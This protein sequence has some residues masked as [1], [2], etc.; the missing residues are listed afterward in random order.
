MRTIR[1]LEEAREIS[2]IRLTRQRRFGQVGD[3]FR[4]SPQTGIFLWGR[5]V[6]KARFFGHDFE[7][8][9]VYIYDAIGSERPG[10]ELL[11]PSNLIIG[12]CVVN[13]LGF[14]RGYWE[15]MASEPLHAQDVRD[16]HLFVRYKGMP[17]YYDVVDEHGRVIDSMGADPKQLGQCAYNNFNN[18]DLLVRNILEDRGLITRSP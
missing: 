14:V 10:P 4:L 16:K 8:K 6:Q 13:N 2:A 1:T 18:V 17:S 9:L 11:T 3:L 12:P 5:L 7:S 15:I